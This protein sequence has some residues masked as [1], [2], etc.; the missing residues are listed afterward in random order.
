MSTEAI[1]GSGQDGEEPTVPAATDGF[2]GED[3]DTWLRRVM[4]EAEDDER[5][6]SEEQAEAALSALAGVSQT[7]G[8][9]G[10]LAQGGPLDVREPDPGLAM[11]AAAACDPGVL[12]A[13][14][15]YH[16]RNKQAPG[17]RLEQ[18]EPGVMRWQTPSGR[19]Y[20]TYPTRYIV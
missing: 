10:G 15:R 19:V 1:P 5:W 14:C 8:D 6:M 3:E 16:H 18:P 11:L 9:L 17:W 13:P 20:T 4:A 7:R 2:C 12:G